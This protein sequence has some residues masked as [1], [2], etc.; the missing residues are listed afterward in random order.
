V[1]VAVPVAV[2]VVARE[3]FAQPVVEAALVMAQHQF[4]AW[5]QAGHGGGQQR[6]HI[7]QA[8]V[9]SQLGHDDQ[10]ERF[11]ARLVVRQAA[12]LVAHVGEAVQAPARLHR[13]ACLAPRDGLFPASGND[14]VLKSFEDFQSEIS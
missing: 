3:V 7:G 2:L 6:A 5:F 12:L 10:V 8:E 9:I 4:A 1:D 13:R 11:R 14:A